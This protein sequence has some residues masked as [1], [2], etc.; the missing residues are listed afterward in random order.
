MPRRARLKPTGY[1]KD[2]RID[3]RFLPVIVARRL[4]QFKAEGMASQLL[5]SDASGDSPNS[6]KGRPLLEYDACLIGRA[7]MEAIVHEAIHLACPW[8]FEPV[9]T[10]VARYVTMVLWHI[11]FRLNE[12]DD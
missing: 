11:G 7:Q 6:Y 1:K 10:P 3:L 8:M 2:G 12:K 5:H 9:V 4:G